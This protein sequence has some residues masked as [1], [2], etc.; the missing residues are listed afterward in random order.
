MSVCVS[1]RIVPR[2]RLSRQV[3]V[4][5]ST[6]QKYKYYWTFCFLYGPCRIEGESVDLSVYPFM[7]AMQRLVKY[8]S[9]ATR[10]CWRRR[11]LC[12]SKESR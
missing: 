6:G 3:S 1:P 12:V 5:K 10:Y 11:F 7:A 9:A 8:V 4:E 2:Q